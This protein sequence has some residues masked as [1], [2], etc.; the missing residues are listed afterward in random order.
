[1]ALVHFPNNSMSSKNISI[2]AIVFALAGGAGYVLYGSDGALSPEPVSPQVESGER[3]L[4]IAAEEFVP[5][6]YEEDGVL[7]GIDIEV[8]KIIFGRLGIQYEVQIIPWSRTWKMV[9]EGAADATFSTSHNIPREKF[10]YFTD[11]QKTFKVTGEVPSDYLWINEFVFFIRSLHKDSFKFE[12]FDQ[13]KEDGYKVAVIT[14][15][16]YID[17]FMEAKLDMHGYPSARDSFKALLDGEVD[18][19]MIDKVTGLSTI[20]QMG[21]ADD[22]TYIPEVVGMKPMLMPFS[23]KST[24]PNVE[25]VMYR[26]YEELQKLRDSGEYDRIYKKYTGE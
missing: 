14:G 3:K 4:L 6:E 9:Q 23:K 1:M 16:S 18:V 2:I 10:V 25:H 26:Y 7:K 20:K 5:F 17:S 15:N 19:Y 12:S 11:E 24:Y 22:I 21:I 13:V 8:S